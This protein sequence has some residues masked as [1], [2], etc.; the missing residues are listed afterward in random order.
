MN[1]PPTLAANFLETSGM[2]VVI[3][4]SIAGLLVALG[5]IRSILSVKVENER[6]AFHAGVAALTEPVPAL[7]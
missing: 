7:V 5:L 4:C 6:L 1:L 3:G 2:P